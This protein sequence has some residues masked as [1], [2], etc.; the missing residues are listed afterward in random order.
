MKNTKTKVLKVVM[1]TVI[2]F[3]LTLGIL[4]SCD[5]EDVMPLADTHT[6]SNEVSIEHIQEFPTTDLCGTVISK[7]LMVSKTKIVGNAFVFNDRKYLYVKALVNDG[8][9][10]HNAYMYVGRKENIPMTPGN[11][12]DYKLFDYR[13]EN[14]GYAKSRM[15]KVPL[16][17]L[18]AS[19]TIG[20]MVELLPDFMGDNPS[21]EM[22]AWAQGYSIGTHIGQKGMLFDHRKALCLRDLPVEIPHEVE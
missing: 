14:V 19:F 3:I 15:F 2:T 5:K 20:L 12:P 16:R 17:D 22:H 13:I 1:L 4:I 6:S 9:M 8:N 21:R 18:D 10:F 7:R 11:D